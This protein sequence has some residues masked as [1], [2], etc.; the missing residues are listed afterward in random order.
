MYSLCISLLETHTDDSHP[1]PCYWWCKE[2]SA[3]RFLPCLA[4]VDVSLLC[5]VIPLLFFL[6]CLWDQASFTLYCCFVVLFC[7][8]RLLCTD[9]NYKQVIF[10]K[11]LFTFL[12][13]EKFENWASNCRQVFIPAESY[14]NVNVSTMC[15]YL[16]G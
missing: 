4:S 3:V 6:V 12:L 1:L 8:L 5:F 7:R 15:S 16:W 14:I 13:L 11:S 10:D 9:N 2:Y